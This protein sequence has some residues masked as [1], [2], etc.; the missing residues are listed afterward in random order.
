MW[1]KDFHGD[2]EHDLVFHGFTKRGY[3]V[4][5]RITTQRPPLEPYPRFVDV[6]P[7]DKT[8]CFI[9]VSHPEGH[10]KGIRNQIIRST[11]ADIGLPIYPNSLAFG[12]KL[13]PSGL[14]C[15]PGGR[16]SPALSLVTA[17]SEAQ[18]RDWYLQRVPSLKQSA[19][20]KYE[21]VG[22]NSVGRPCA[23]SFLWSK[24][25]QRTQISMRWEIPVRVQTMEEFDQQ[26]PNADPDDGS[27]VFNATGNH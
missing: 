19:S 5:M 18:V 17:D 2:P 23:I 24:Q 11:G 9:G 15:I 21:Y 4:R 27:R 10:K 8:F 22:F 12:N 14:Y 6:R 3:Q 13:E 7:T 25:E 16:Y 20:D 26:N 1:D